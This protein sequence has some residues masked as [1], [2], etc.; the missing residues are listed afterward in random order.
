MPRTITGELRKWRLLHNKQS[1]KVVVGTMYYDIH[2]IYFDGDEAVIQF[3][4]WEEDGSNFYAVTNQS[5]IR[6]PKD[7]ELPHDPRKAN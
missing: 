1:D 7:E 6:C 2:G 5:S 3:I 4:K